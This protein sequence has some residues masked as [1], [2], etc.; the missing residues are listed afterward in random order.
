MVTFSLFECGPSGGATGDPFRDLPAA[1]VTVTKIRVT[2]DRNT[3]VGGHP[4]LLNSIQLTYSNHRHTDLH[5]QDHGT[6]QTID[7]AEQE[8]IVEVSGKYGDF[9]DQLKIRTSGDRDFG[10]FGGNGGRI[11]K[12]FKYHVPDGMAIVGFVGSSGACVDALGILYRP[13]S[14]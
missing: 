13:I 7:L 1:G 6:P 5:G 14:G 3:S 10:P 4:K 2:G 12:E 8:Y 9:I 11:V